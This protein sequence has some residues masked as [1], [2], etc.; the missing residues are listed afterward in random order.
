MRGGFSWWD[1]SGIFG[2]SQVLAHTPL[3]H[4]V[5]E[6]ETCLYWAELWL[7]ALFM[8]SKLRGRGIYCFSPWLHS[9]LISFCKESQ[10]L[11]SF[12]HRNNTCLQTL[13]V[14][15]REFH[16]GCFLQH[17]QKLDHHKGLLLLIFERRAQE[18]SLPKRA[19]N[20]DFLLPH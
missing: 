18:K 4:Q 20:A 1:R 19:P 7:F 14:F 11:S 17:R 8:V 13:G 3:S 5:N 6:A 2:I 16:L 15:L 9:Y 12:S 10:D